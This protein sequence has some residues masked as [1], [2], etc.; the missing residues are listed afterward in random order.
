[1]KRALLR[2][3]I[4][5]LAIVIIAFIPG[6]SAYLL[7]FLVPPRIYIILGVLILAALM[8]I[9]HNQKGGSDD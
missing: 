4:I 9:I 8:T 3:L 7:R 5:A 2:G 1:M 6:L